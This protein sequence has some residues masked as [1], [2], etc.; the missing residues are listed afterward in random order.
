LGSG[1]GFVD[2]GI[3]LVG[4]GMG[5]ELEGRGEGLGGRGGEALGQEGEGGRIGVEE[6]GKEGFG[7]VDCLAGVDALVAGGGRF[8]AG[9]GE[10]G[11]GAEF[12]VDQRLDG[13][14]ED[15]GAADTGFGLGKS[16]LGG[17]HGE[18]A[19]GDEGGEIVA[20]TDEGGGGVALS[21]AGNVY[22]GLAETKVERLPGDEEADGAAPDVAGAVL[23][24]GGTGDGGKPLGNEEPED[25]V[26]GGAVELGDGVDAGEVGGAGKAEAGG[27]FVNLRLGH[28]DGAITVNRLANGVGEAEFEGLG[29]GGAGGDETEGGEGGKEG[30][31][32]EGRGKGLSPKGRR[33]GKG[34]G[35]GLSPKGRRAGGWEEH[36]RIPAVKD[37]A[38][39][40][41]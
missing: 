10:I 38:T 7:S 20:G 27:S 12:G 15:F 9:A 40:K 33:R 17:E 35:K 6:A 30:V 3:L 28:L 5:G 31:P 26:A 36:R 29:G 34:R 4:G 37:Q 11:A 8:G 21:G 1:G 41:L 32:P 16:L 14:L 24:Q 2:G 22:V 13:T 19:V 25:V 23:L 39:V 18:E